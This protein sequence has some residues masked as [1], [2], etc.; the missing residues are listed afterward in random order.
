MDVNLTISLMRGQMGAVIEKAVNVAVETVLGEMIRVVGLKFEEIKREMNTKEKENE[1]IRRML[2]T[3]RSQMKTMRK[4]ITV[5]TAKDQNRLYHGDMTQSVGV[6]TQRGPTSTVSMCTKASNPCIRP[7]VTEPAPVAGP[8]WV[9]QHMHVSKPQNIQEPMRS[10]NHIGDIHIEE[11]HGSS[12]HKAVDHSSH[13]L[14]DSQGLLS[15]T[16]D[17][18]WGQN[19]LTSADTE[20]TDMPDTGMLST[21]MMTDDPSQTAVRM[22][23]GAP[24]LKIKK[25]EPE[26]EIVCVKDEPSEAASSSR[27]EYP[28]HELQQQVGEPDLGVPLDLPGSFQALQSPSTSAELT[29]P[30]FVGLDPSTSDVREMS[31]G[32]FETNPC[33]PVERA[34]LEL[35]GEM[36]LKISH[37]TALVQALLGNRCPVPLLQEEEDDE[38]CILPV[39]SMEDLDQLDLQLRDREVMQKLV[40][41]LSTIGGHTMRK[42]V[43]RICAKVLGSSVAKKL[44]WCGRGDKRGLNK[45]HVGTLIIA[46]AMRNKALHAPTEAEAEKCIKDFLRWAPG[47]PSPNVQ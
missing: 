4:Y 42:T 46:A 20:H 9:R 45:T 12:A 14:V 44:N 24:S 47:R 3:S 8:S 17:P 5:L 36:G 11:I 40:N 2:E 23:F 32:S 31:P 15:E 16:S 27:F 10:E 33:T 1:N 22:N 18:I 37:L 34:I 43:S 7:R 28:N 13:Q 30:A 6:H 29:I 39:M 25:E 26:V 35:Q 21:S 38:D 19:P 41:K